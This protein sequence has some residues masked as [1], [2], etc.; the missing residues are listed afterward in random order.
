MLPV[1]CIRR[2][3]RSSRNHHRYLHSR[4]Q[5]CSFRSNQMDRMRNSRTRHRWWHSRRSCMHWRRYIRVSA[6]R[7]NWTR[8]TRWTRPNTYRL[9]PNHRRHRI[10]HSLQNRRT[11]PCSRSVQR[12]RRRNQMGTR[13]KHSFRHRR[14]RSHRSCMPMVSY[15]PVL[16]SRM[17]CRQRFRPSRCGLARDPHRSRSRPR[18]P[19]HHTDRYSPY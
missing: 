5:E 10:R 19:N 12:I 17:R 11:C 4:I 15:I 6:H 7:D 9:H 1:H 3:H 8:R 14:W 13:P 16:S 2:T 18:P